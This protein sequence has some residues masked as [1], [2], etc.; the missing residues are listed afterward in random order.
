MRRVILSAILLI[1]SLTVFTGCDLNSMTTL[2]EISRPYVGE[3]ECKTLRL[4]AEDMTVRF[5]SVKLNLKYDGE[6]I[7]SYKGKSANKGEWSGRY[8][9][10]PDGDEITLSVKE[11]ARTVERTFPIDKGTII[12]DWNFAGKL[13]HAEFSFPK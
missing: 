8:R 13:L 6:F 10:S 1:G 4:G 5:E 7:L 2:S 3:Y 11:S 12:V 9:V